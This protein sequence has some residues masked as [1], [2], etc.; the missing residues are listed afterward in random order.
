MQGLLELDKKNNRQSLIVDLSNVSK[1][2]RQET[3]C[4]CWPFALNFHVRS[5]SSGR[6]SYVT[7]TEARKLNSE[8]FAT[9]TA[10][11]SKNV[12]NLC[13]RSSLQYQGETYTPSYDVPV[14]QPNIDRWYAHN[15]QTSIF[16]VGSFLSL[17][18]MPR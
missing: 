14:F 6:G 8:F 17:S 15:Y 7:Y 13:C 4:T 9:Y 16:H 3:R 5:Y 1:Y 10:C 11:T 18:L 12:H 2:L